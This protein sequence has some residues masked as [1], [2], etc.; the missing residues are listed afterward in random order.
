MRGKV[1]LSTRLTA[2]FLAF[3]LVPLLAFFLLFFPYLSSTMVDAQMANLGGLANANVSDLE[4]R[5]NVIFQEGQRL[6][7]DPRVLTVLGAT[8]EGTG[9]AERADLEKYLSNMITDSI[10]GAAVYSVD[11]SV[12]AA[13]DK[14]YTTAIVREMAVVKEAIA[15]SSGRGKVSEL[16]PSIAIEG[17]NAIFF[18]VPIV[19]RDYT[20][21]SMDGD[22]LLGVLLMEMSP[23]VLDKKTLNFRQGETGRMV[24]IDRN[25]RVLSH[26]DP[27]YIGTTMQDTT[28]KTLFSDHLAGRVQNTGSGITKIEGVSLC[29]GYRVLGNMP[30]MLV[31]YQEESEVRSQEVLIILYAVLAMIGLA[32]LSFIIS[33]IVARSS[34]APIKR[35]TAAFRQTAYNQFTP[36][37]PSGTT[38][39]VELGQGYN[40]MINLLGKNITQLSDSNRQLATTI[41]EL[42][43][44]RDRL[45]FLRDVPNDDSVMQATAEFNLISGELLADDAFFKMLHMDHSV[46]ALSLGEFLRQHVSEDEI[47]PLYDMLDNQVDQIH[48]LLHISTPGGMLWLQVHARIFY[49]IQGEPTKVSATL[50]DVSRAQESPEEDA[51]TDS[52]TGLSTKGPFLRMVEDQLKS[53]DDEG[54]VIL[55]LSL[56][57]IPADREGENL[58]LHNLILRLTADRLRSFVAPDGM[59][60]RSGDNQFLL[61]LPTFSG[62][63]PLENRMAD[64]NQ[65]LAA[66]IPWKDSAITLQMMAGAVIYPQD[67][68]TAQELVNKAQAALTATAELPGTHFMLYDESI[69]TPKADA[70]AVTLENTHRIRA[71]TAALDTAIV[72]GNLTLEYQPIVQLS[73][74]EVAGIEATIR[75]N[76]QGLGVVSAGELIPLAEQNNMMIPIGTWIL[77]ESCRYVKTLRER[78]NQPIFVSVNISGSQLEQPDF[79]D[80]VYL[81]LKDAGL[82]GNALQIEISESRWM[83]MF[84]AKL[85]VIKTIRSLGVRIALDDYGAGTSALTNLYNMPLDVLKIDKSFLI[86][87]VASQGKEFILKTLVGL[88]HN[89]NLEVV[90]VGVEHHKRLDTI[91][92]LNYDMAQGYHFCPPLPPAALEV[93][94]DT[95]AEQ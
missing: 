74:N 31:V 12:K 88:A 49:N 62:H 42:E 67:N 84:V 35:L 16:R 72:D 66:P 90:A 10:N 57:G 87:A 23:S 9:E 78:Q 37:V 32:L 55:C 53:A 89:L 11:G 46:S 79:A 21:A 68:N 20:M 40:S 38:E 86:G 85:P 45:Q 1:S 48:P 24:I 51:G 80:V 59:A 70:M 69:H 56:F 47:M 58:Q 18:A 36:I 77:Q 26:T 91:L 17:D 2:S 29:Y 14:S 71:I 5:V 15:D 75:M 30:W 25:G 3:S 64:L 33:R 54:G 50:L 73:N 39:F 28:W 44:E 95:R 7:L 41:A 6:S 82:P 43:I 13:S 92:K 93:Y 65:V 27:I 94:L 52:T 34:L 81:A 19:H 22:T 60:A 83:E 76:V 8:T 63:E 61:H 4:E